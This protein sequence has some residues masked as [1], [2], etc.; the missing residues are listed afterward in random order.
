MEF[1][2]FII[3]VVALIVAIMAYRRAGGG[4]KDLR[5]STAEMLSKMEQ[6]LRNREAEK[7]TGGPPPEKIA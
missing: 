2:N 6:R 7:Q 3:A 4:I 1:I 5:E